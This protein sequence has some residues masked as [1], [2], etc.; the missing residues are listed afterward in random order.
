M[1]F[2][3]EKLS[4]PFPTNKRFKICFKS[5]FEFIPVQKK[6][7]QKCYKRS[8]FLILHFDRL[9]NG[10]DYSS[11]PPPG[12]A[13]AYTTFGSHYDIPGLDDDEPYD[14]G[15]FPMLHLHSSRVYTR[16]ESY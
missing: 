5:F 7:S 9:A 14:F 8:I 11:P 6:L 13:T 16:I 2:I 1:R 4:P 15:E 12:Y 10:E 3:F